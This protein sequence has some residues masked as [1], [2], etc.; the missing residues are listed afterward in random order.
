MSVKFLVIGTGN[1]IVSVHN[2]IKAAT[3]AC[4]KHNREFPAMP[5]IVA[6]SSTTICSCKAGETA[7]TV[8]DVQ[9]DEAVSYLESVMSALKIIAV[10]QRYSSNNGA[11][12]VVI[13][14][15]GSEIV[16]DVIDGRGVATESK[17]VNE[18]AT[19]GEVALAVEWHITNVMPKNY[20]GGTYTVRGSRK[21][22]KGTEVLVLDFVDEGR[23]GTK[24]LVQ[25]EGGN[26]NW[27][28]TGCISEGFVKGVKPFWA[29]CGIDETVADETVSYIAKPTDD[30]C[31]WWSVQL[32]ADIELSSARIPAPY[33]RKGADLE[34]REGDMIIDSEANHHRKN[35]GYRVALGVCVDGEVKFLSPNASKKA[36]IKLNG[37]KDLMHESGDVAGCVRI[38]VWLRRQPDLSIAV[39]QL[40]TA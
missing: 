8:S 5:A 18:Y 33:L 9:T 36:Y 31:A 3:A 7:V 34:L 6:E 12:D 37:G 23:F 11:Y 26:K 27:I 29:D 40:L 2:N 39:K 20:I 10:D 38:A 35:R 17:G 24:V 14:W 15:N 32:P 25:D 28:S 21:I 13:M 30:R 1:A 4:E 22:K 19:K 16:E